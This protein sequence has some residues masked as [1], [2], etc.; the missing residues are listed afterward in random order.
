M[1]EGVRG[2]KSSVS[3]LRASSTVACF[4]GNASSQ[5][6]N[7]HQTVKRYC[8]PQVILGKIAKKIAFLRSLS[9]NFVIAFIWRSFDQMAQLP[10][11]S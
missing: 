11:L 9:L 6:V 2:K 7:F 4:V 3:R 8:L 1:R 5:R 10:R